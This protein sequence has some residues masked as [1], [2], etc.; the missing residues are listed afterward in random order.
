MTVLIL[1]FSCACHIPKFIAIVAKLVL[2]TAEEKDRIEKLN[3]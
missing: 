3:L 2:F 1:D